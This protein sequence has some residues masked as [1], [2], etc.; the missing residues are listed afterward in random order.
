MARLRTSDRNSDGRVAV[1]R[2]A[3]SLWRTT[4]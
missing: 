2:S 4:A 1:E 3:A